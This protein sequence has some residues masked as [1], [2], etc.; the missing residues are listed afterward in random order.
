[1]IGMRVSS[2]IASVKERKTTA[3]PLEKSSY[4]DLTVLW[5][6]NIYKMNMYILILRLDS[7]L[8]YKW[9]HILL[10][11]WV[12]SPTLSV[13]FSTLL[14]TN[15]NW[16]RF[17]EPCLLFW[18]WLH[19]MVLSTKIHSYEFL[20]CVWKSWILRDLNSIIYISYFNQITIIFSFYYFII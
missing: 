11:D 13:L 14:P 20:C 15:S 7:T 3:N 4:W 16:S 12:I 10:L 6:S 1:M 19:S 5:K 18:I 9:V 8:E 17:C 2:S